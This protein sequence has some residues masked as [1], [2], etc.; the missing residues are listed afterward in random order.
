MW[1]SVL[2]MRQAAVL[3]P[4]YKINMFHSLQNIFTCII[5]LSPRNPARWPS[6]YCYQTPRRMEDQRLSFLPRLEFLLG[7]SP[8]QVIP[9][10]L[11]PTSYPQ[12]E[13]LCSPAA[14]IGVSSSLFSCL[15]DVKPIHSMYVFVPHSN[16]F[17]YQ[18]NDDFVRWLQAS[19]F[20]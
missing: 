7:V 19:T 15:R 10:G 4:Q 6:L 18:S 9:C 3:P 5:A 17:C 20:V 2:R 16:P 1:F 12:S 8:G 14:S 13:I 11:S